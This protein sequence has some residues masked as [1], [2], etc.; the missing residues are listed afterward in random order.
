MSAD[1]SVFAFNVMDATHPAELCVKDNDG[2]KQLTNFNE[3]LLED[4]DLSTPERFTFRNDLGEDID[5]WIMK[6]VSFKEDEK[7]PTALEIHGGPRNI[8][9]DGLFYE[10]QVLDANGFVVIYTSPRGSGGYGEDYA[11]AVISHR[12]ECAYEDLMA[13]VDESLKLYP[14]SKSPSW[15]AS[16]P[17]S[18]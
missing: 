1:G 17:S 4:L 16:T 5:G 11:K 10:F 2:E 7:Y 12:A 8:F 6:P 3:R 15:L 18:S 14:L 13:F 9:G